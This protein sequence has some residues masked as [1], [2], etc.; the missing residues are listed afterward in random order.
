MKK[1][2]L[3]AFMTVL[4]LTASLPAEEGKGGYPGSFLQLNL[5]AR[6]M[7]MGGAFY[8]VSDDAVALFYNPAGCAQLQWNA[9][10][11]SYRHMDFDRRMGF[12]AASFKARDEAVLALGWIHAGAGNFIGRD[13]EGFVT[14][15]EFSYSDNALAI[16]FARAFGKYVMLGATGKYYITKVADISSNTLS[17]DIAAMGILSKKNRLSE[18]SRIDMLRVGIVVGNLGGMHRWST[19]DYWGQFGLPGV[20]SEESFPIFVG[21]G[22]SLLMLDSTTL[23]A[24]DARY[25]QDQ[26]LRLYAGGEYVIG[27]LLSLRAGYADGR[28]TFGGGIYKKFIYYSLSLDYAFASGLEGEAADHLFT[29][30]FAFR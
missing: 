18:D 26:D 16:A 9:V 19:G 23:I 29:L 3:I 13:N 8:G 21:G 20:S 1:I 4:V 15:D 10:S 2:L 22:A 7:G 27:K 5:S 11:A 30:G 17:F 28:L 25:Y 24:A 6:V 14:G 12:I